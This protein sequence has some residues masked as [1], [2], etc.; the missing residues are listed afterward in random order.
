MRRGAV[1]AAELAAAAES[2]V[3]D[4]SQGRAIVAEA[5]FRN[6]RRERRLRIIVRRW[7]FLLECVTEDNGEDEALGG[8]VI[9]LNGIDNIVDQWAVL[10]A[11]WAS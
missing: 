11:N 4:S 8:V 10:E 7:L 6:V 9:E 3:I 1:L 2:G 5:L